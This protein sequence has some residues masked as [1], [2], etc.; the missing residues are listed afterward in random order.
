M[1]PLDRARV[2][3]AFGW[4]VTLAASLCL[5]VGPSVLLVACFGVLVAPLSIEFGWSRGQ[6]SAAVSFMAVAIMIASVLQGMLIDR[7]GVRRVVLCSMVLFAAALMGLR[8]LPASLWTFYAA[9]FLLPLLAVGLWPGSYLKTVSGWFDRHLGLATGVTNAGIGL[10]TILIP[11]VIAW[12]IG[13]YGIRNAFTGIGCLAVIALPVALWRLRERGSRANSPDH[14]SARQWTYRD[15]AREPRYRRIVGSFLLLGVT[16]TGLLAGIV[17][18]LMAKGLSQS[19]AVAALGG[20]GA[21]ALCGRLGT[22]ALLDRISARRVFHLLASTTVISL[23]LLML[24]TPA[25]L[26]IA[27]TVTLGFLSGGEFDVLAYSLRRYFG[28]ASFGKMYGVAFSGFQMG[29][30]FGAALLAGSIGWTNSYS[31]GLGAFT[32]AV[33][34][35]MVLFNRLGPYPEGSRQP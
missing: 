20:C 9:W 16:G 15:M 11:P 25:W 18:I 21:A 31:A 29:A 24:D 14:R 3:G 13:R 28:L 2:D 32:V 8:W 30:A 26:A 17:P 12:M 1:A 22:G 4:S 23:V 10:G 6:I 35:S 33:A 34:L 7:A 19:T 5:I 27:A